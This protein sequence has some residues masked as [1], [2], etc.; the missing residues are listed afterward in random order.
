MGEVARE[1]K[2]SERGTAVAIAGK[3]GRGPP[4]KQVF[5]LSHWGSGFQHHPETMVLKNKQAYGF[6]FP[7]TR[8]LYPIVF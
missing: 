8:R 6:V 5:F 3:A 1:V 7:F 2:A 4:P